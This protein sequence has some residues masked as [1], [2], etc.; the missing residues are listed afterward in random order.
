M[1]CEGSGRKLAGLYNL[2][3]SDTTVGDY[4]RLAGLH[5]YRFIGINK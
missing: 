2:S 1:A 5:I 4:Y 3:I